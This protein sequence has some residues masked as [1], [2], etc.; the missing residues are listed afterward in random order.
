LRWVLDHL[1]DKL[2]VL[3][4]GIHL[5]V[6]GR[7]MPPWLMELEKK[8]VSMQG[9]VQDAAAF[10]DDKAILLAP[11][12]SGGGMRVKF[13][14]AMLQ[15]K[16]VITTSIGAEGIAGRDGEHFLIA[17]SEAGM[18]AILDKCL[19]DPEW[20]RYIGANARSLVLD[21]YNS[22]VIAQRLVS[23]YKSISDSNGKQEPGTRSQEL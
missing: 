3:H 22:R 17:E 8:N 5:Y 15:R 7:N 23:L 1:W 6:A 12:F 9:D 10:M 16:V 21:Q 18:L 19:K 2:V 14:E 13:I 4:P 11:Y 20:M